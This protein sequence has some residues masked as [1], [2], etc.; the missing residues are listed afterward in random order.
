MWNSYEA[1]L[2]SSYYTG[3]LLAAG[4]L[5]SKRGHYQLASVHCYGRCL[6]SLRLPATHSAAGNQN[7]DL[8]V[9]ILHEKD[10]DTITATVSSINVGTMYRATAMT[11]LSLH[12]RMANSNSVAH[13]V[14]LPSQ[15][16]T[17]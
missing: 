14:A 16:F 7:Q 5:L 17:N 8:L 2:L 1:K 10:M 3:Q 13:F 6:T 12:F 11:S 9:N 15:F 4:D